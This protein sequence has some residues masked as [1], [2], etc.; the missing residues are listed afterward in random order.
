MDYSKSTFT[1][2][3]NGTPAVVFKA[4][5]HSEADEICQGWTQYHWQQLPKKEL[6]GYELPPLVKV[7]LAHANERA[8]YDTEGKSSEFH[9]GVKIVYLI[10]LD[11]LHETGGS[12]DRTG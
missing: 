2:E 11:T 1:I 8:R 12:D 9:E 5:W 7:R 3:I 4:K 10:D 6:R